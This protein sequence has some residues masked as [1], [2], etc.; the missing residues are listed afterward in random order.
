MTLVLYLR[1]FVKEGQTDAISKYYQASR[2]R[3]LAYWTSH[4]TQYILSLVG[5][6]PILRRV[7]TAE[8]T[9]AMIIF[10]TSEMTIPAKNGSAADRTFHWRMHCLFVT[11]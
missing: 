10:F 2:P 9:G 11:D 3:P 5:V 1:L 7:M 6:M 4:C 8:S